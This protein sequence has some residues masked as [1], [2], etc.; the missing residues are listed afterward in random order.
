MSLLL[1]ALNKNKNIK[2]ID[3]ATRKMDQHKKKP[4]PLAVVACMFLIWF[5]LATKNNETQKTKIETPVEHI[6]VAEAKINNFAQ[7]RRLAAHAL[8][9]EDYDQAYN[10]Y[11]EL[12]QNEATTEN[13]LGLG[14]AAL[15]TQQ[16]QKAEQYFEKSLELM[17]ED[18]IAY[19]FVLEQ[20]DMLDERSAQFRKIDP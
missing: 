19:T 1:K 5:W 9:A 8:E 11:K 12:V 14:I 18:H 16:Y 7:E 10:L 6:E 2:Y 17:D 20:L 15:K 3:H 4:L 13:Y